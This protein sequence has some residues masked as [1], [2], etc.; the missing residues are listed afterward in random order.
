MVSWPSRSW[1]SSLSLRVRASSSTLCTSSSSGACVVR[2]AK[3]SKPISTS[4]LQTPHCR[5]PTIA[6]PP[7]DCQMARGKT[8][9]NVRASTCFP[10]RWFVSTGDLASGM[11]IFAIAL[12]TLFA[13]IIGMKLPYSIFLLGITA[14]WLFIYAMAVTGVVSHKENLH[15][16][17][18]AWVS[19]ANLS[20]SLT[21]LTL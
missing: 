8:K 2:H 1:A 15:V 13:V 21:D 12:H 10:E 20:E 17:A 16:R 7:A 9:I 14:L 3:G 4:N 5:Y 11:R 6:Y 18:R 19:V